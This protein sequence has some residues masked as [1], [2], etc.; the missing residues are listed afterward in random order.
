[1]AED[2]PGPPGSGS[3]DDR[4]DEPPTEPTQPLGGAAQPPMP[5]PSSGQL[6]GSQQPPGYGPAAQQPQPYAQQ[7][8]YGQQPGYGY[9]PG[10]Q[11]EALATAALVI[12]IAG[13]FICPPVG[14]IVALVLANSAKQR[15]EASGGRL[16]GLEQARAARI[17]AIIELVLTAIVLLVGIIVGAIA[18][19]T[20]GGHDEQVEVPTTVSAPRSMNA[21][22]SSSWT[23]VASSVDSLST[24]GWE[25]LP[26]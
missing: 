12:A 25:R 17:I 5:S 18:I 19:T 6:G 8:G 1:M 9:P 20:S 21:G 7:Y 4:P 3:R 11:T 26:D 23:T 16:S 13:F 15:I 10:P 2:L 22:S 14:A 24:S